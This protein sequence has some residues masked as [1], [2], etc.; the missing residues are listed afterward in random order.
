[1]TA[2]SSGAPLICS[3]LDHTASSIRCVSAFPGLGCEKYVSP[4]LVPL[5]LWFILP[6]Y[7]LL[8]LRSTS[9]QCFAPSLV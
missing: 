1:M 4:S 5:Y 7:G 8:V 3:A 6:N 9:L 2:L